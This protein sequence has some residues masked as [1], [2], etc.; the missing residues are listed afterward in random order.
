ME[1]INLDELNSLIPP[2]DETARA[3]AL[4]KWS[5]AA[6]PLKSLGALEDIVTRMAA[7]KGSARF[8]ISPRE[9][10]VMCADNGVVAR[11]VTQTDES[12]TSLVA[13]DLAEGKSSA[14]LMARVAGCGVAAI[15][16]GVK[17]PPA[18]AGLISRRVAAG[19]ADFT[20]GAAMT[21]GQALSAVA[22]GV[23]A[24]RERARDGCQ[25]LLAGEMGIGNTTTG[26]AVACVL[27]GLDPEAVTGRGAGLSGAGL[28]RKVAAIRRGIAVNRPSPLD[29]LDTLAKVGGFDIAAMAGLFIGGALCRVPVVID[30]VISAAA[31]LAAARMCPACREAM[32]ASH[33]SGEQAARNVLG[34][35]GLR[36][37]IDAGL[38]LGEGTGALCL[39]P[40][41]DMAMAI[42]DGPTFGDIG[43]E[44]YTPQA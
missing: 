3:A 28:A 44:A 20:L 8:S 33:M 27:L 29:A 26:T 18:A 42:Y 9:L 23:E 12:V 11:G 2:P 14:N 25:L 22:V 6:K 37:V 21:R 39:L 5:K 24:A 43:M 7:V 38:R 13:A 34:A 17:N 40:L 4:E 35:L 10:V 36:P 30:G 32:I 16:V 31:A 1:P 41:L 15:D 19:T